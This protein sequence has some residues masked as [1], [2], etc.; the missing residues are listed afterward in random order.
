MRLHSC[1]SAVI[2]NTFL[3]FSL[4]SPLLK[5]PIVVIQEFWYHGNV[6]SHFSSLL[7]IDTLTQSPIGARELKQRRFLSDARQHVSQH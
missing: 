6:T 4:P 5:L 7:D 3:P 1:N 2:A